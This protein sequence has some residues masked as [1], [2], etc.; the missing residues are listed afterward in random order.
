M[1]R[2][3]Q[4]LD[5]RINNISN[6]INRWKTAETIASITGEMLTIAAGLLAFSV[7]YYDNTFLGYL[8]GASGF[9]GVG[10]RQLSSFCY[11]KG[12]K[13]EQVLDTLLI[14]SGEEAIPDIVTSPSD[15]KFSE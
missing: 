3:K 5:E 7:T 14:A 2:R 1:S 15:E 12:H 10:L 9:S 11:R 13:Y 6:S 8:S 4:I